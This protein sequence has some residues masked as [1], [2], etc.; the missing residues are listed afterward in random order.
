MLELLRANEIN[1]GVKE[2][3]MKN[4]QKL[5]EIHTEIVHFSTLG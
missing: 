2:M 5:Y 1:A 3:K 4:P